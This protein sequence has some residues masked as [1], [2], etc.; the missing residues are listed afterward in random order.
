MALPALLSRLFRVAPAPA[1]PARL[2]PMRRAARASYDAAQTNDENTRH[3]AKADALS[4]DAAA[5]A[6]VRQTLRYRARY[7]VANNSYARGMIVTLASD[8]IGTGPRLQMLS[9]SPDFNR[10]VEREWTRWAAEMALADKLRTMRQAR[11][12]D[13][14]AFAAITANPALASAVKLDLRLL[15]ADLVSAPYALTGT[16]EAADADGITFDAA[17]NPVAYSVLVAHPGSSAAMVATYRTI[18]ARYMLH[19]YRAD[20]PGQH[21][22]V[23]EITPALPLFALLRR[24]TLSCVT[25]AETAANFAAILY[26]DGP[27]NQEDS[28]PDP[29]D[30]FSLERNMVTTMPGGWKLGQ[31]KPEQP[32]STY[33]D[34]KREVLSEICRCLSMP[35][36]VAAGDSADHNYASGRLDFLVYQR[37]IAT[38]REQTGRTILDRLLAEFLAELTLAGGRAAPLNPSVADLPPHQ[39]FWDTAGAVDPSKEATAQATRLANHTSTYA[40]EYAKEGRDWEAELRQRGAELALLKELGIPANLANPAATLPTAPATEDE[41]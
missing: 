18:P 9:A 38:D 6:S 36:I 34:F 20:R 17:G 22:G 35:Y 11:C 29:M 27:A 7:E 41:A 5:S 30:S 15:E 40:A 25:A 37:Q 33:K 4:A 3:W 21:R 28:Q 13:G 8:T 19:T 32:P 16:G 23:P 10:A 26:S 1:A 14:E 24:F 31:M 2:S 39:W 12:Q